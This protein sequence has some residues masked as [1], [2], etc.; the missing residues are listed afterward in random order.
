[1][2]AAAPTGKT[3]YQPKARILVELAEEECAVETSVDTFR[4]LINFP[5]RKDQHKWTDV[6]PT[7]WEWVD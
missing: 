1:M 5:R 4:E 7:V 2:E 3:K 6:E